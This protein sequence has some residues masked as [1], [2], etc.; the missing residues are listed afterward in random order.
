MIVR[1]RRFLEARVGRRLFFLFVLSA[2]VPLAALAALS[3][4]Q[5]RDILLEQG[6]QRLAATAKGFGTALFERLLQA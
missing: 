4:V 2:F 3:Y 5:L 1:I 6:Q